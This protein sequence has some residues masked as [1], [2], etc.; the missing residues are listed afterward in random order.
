MTQFDTKPASSLCYRKCP[1]RYII[2]SK[3]QYARNSKKIDRISHYSWY[4][5]KNRH[6]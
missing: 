4:I 5:H 2:E 1:V 3:V 6:K